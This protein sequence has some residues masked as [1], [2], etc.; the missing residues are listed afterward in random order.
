M[1]IRAT[2]N[3]LAHNTLMQN[4]ASLGL[5]QL[6][7]YAIPLLI[8]PFITRAL[9]PE[10]FGK[11]S[12]AQNIIAYLTIIVNYGFE[13]T[14][15]QDVALN[16]ENKD[17][18]RHIFWSVMKFKTVLLSISLIAL[19]LLYFFF[20]KV[21]EDP[22]LYIY[23]WLI[24]VGFVMFPTWFFQ[25]MENMKKMA[26]FN[27]ITKLCGAILTIAVVS[28]PEDYRLYILVLSL[29]YIAVG[30]VSFAYVLRKYDLTPYQTNKETYISGIKKGFPVFINNIFVCLYTTLG[31]TIIGIYLSD[32][33]VGIYTGAQ[34]IIVAILMLTSMPLNTSLYPMMSRKFRENR[35]E[36][37]RFFKKTLKISI[38]AGIIISAMTFFLSELVV[39]ILLGGMYED[40]ITIIRAL[41]PLPLLV[42]VASI[43]TVVGLYGLQLQKKAPI[44]GFTSGIICIIAN[45]LFIPKYGAIGAAIAWACAQIAEILIDITLL[46]AN[47]IKKIT[48]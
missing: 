21:N 27:F 3:K 23:A 29:S 43:L 33:E 42:I 9:G 14:A 25:G 22:S 24:N 8:M 10:A 39:K 38:L 7:N 34:K 17:K 11:A 13:Y 41:S 6:A 15:T 36:G 37:I 46:S 18:T 2:Y 44:V 28:S 20:D 35:T 47:R 26:V 32:Y 16:R 12:Y 1:G 19:A 48:Q 30:V 40:S 31:I 5:V 4:I 45:L